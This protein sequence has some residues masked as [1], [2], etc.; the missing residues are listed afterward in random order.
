MSNITVFLDNN[1]R[2]HDRPAVVAPSEGLELTFGDLLSWMSRT[3]RALEDQGI[4]KGDRVCIYLDNCPEYL[5]S[6]FAVWRL[7]AVAVPANSSLREDEL[8]HLVTD[9]G[10]RTLIHDASGAAVAAEAVRQ[11]AGTCAAL[12]IDQREAT[13]EDAPV[14][15]PVN[16][17]L[18]DL[19]QLQYTAGTTGTPKG[20]ML[21]HGNLMASLE[22]ER[23]VLGLT[24]NDRYLGIYPMGHVGVS[25]GLSVLRSGG[26]YVI[27]KRFSP[28]DYIALCKTYRISVLSGMP[29]VI[30][31]LC[32]AP[33]GT[34]EALRTV[35]L[36]ISGGGQLLPTVW[37]AF[38]RRYGIPVANAYGL[39]ETVVV[40]TGTITLPGRPELTGNYTSVGVPAGYSE[41]KIVNP[42]DPG[43]SLPPG[44]D[45]EI[46]LRG[47]SVA[48]GYWNLPDA[49]AESFLPDG[50]FLSGDIGHLDRSGLLYITDRKKDMIIMSG[51]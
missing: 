44:E 13:P 33:E 39:S 7:G 27:M 38:D 4:R 50:W 11:S 34:E 49:T 36:I 40:G 41:V 43:E 14:Y 29:P 1:A 5:V 12:H 3:A 51:W 35:R 46:A 31:S 6:Y 37:E 32:S 30:H 16:C 28:A 45:G 20:A 21:T 42:E 18:D 47:P 25:W 22:T 48:K 17:G 9:A 8:L 24:W 26:S 10:A 15:P 19:C 2:I 23:E